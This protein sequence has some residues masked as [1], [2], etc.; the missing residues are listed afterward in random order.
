[1]HRLRSPGGCPWDAE[2]THASLVKYL[3]EEAYETADAIEDGD[4]AA[5]REELGDVLLQVVFHSRIAAERPD[6]WTID[7]VA[8]DIVEKLI[9]RHPHV[10]GSASAATASDVEANWEQLKAVEKGRTSA[11]DGVPIGQ[12]AL[13]LASALLGRT[14]KAGL[15]V[16]VTSSVEVPTTV[17]DESVGELLLAVVA[18]ARS[19]GMQL[20]DL[21]ASAERLNQTGLAE[22]SAQLYEHWIA[23]TESPHRHIACFNWGTVL[24]ALRRPQEAER[25]YRQALQDL[26]LPYDENLVMRTESF[27]ESEGARGLARLL[28]AKARFTAVLAGNDL[29][30]LG[31]YD[32]FNERGVNCPDDISLVGFNDMPIVDKLSPAL[33][34]V[35]VPQ[36]E[37]GTEAARLLLDRVNNVGGPAKTVHLSLDLV[38]RSSTAEPRASAGSRSRRAAVSRPVG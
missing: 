32:V 3:L 16:P 30:A 10:F 8:G 14:A 35:H 37:I 17:D 2:Q 13:A 21:L 20:T 9:R 23:G 25:A 4:D 12:P 7:D 38:V 1:M 28:D 31:C 22:A 5:L 6:G 15:D 29:H 33:T 19:G 26:A 27:S 34:T 36:Y 11:V 18:L 24:G